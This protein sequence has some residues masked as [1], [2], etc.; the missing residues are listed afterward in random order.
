MSL[1]YEIANTVPAAIVSFCV[2]TIK[3]SARLWVEATLTVGTRD[4]SRVGGVGLTVE[5]GDRVIVW[6]VL[7]VTPG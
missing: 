2:C 5:I 4:A 6:V 3:V 7:P 1:W